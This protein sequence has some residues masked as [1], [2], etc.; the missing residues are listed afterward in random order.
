MQTGSVPVTADVERQDRSEATWNAVAPGWAGYADRIDELAAGITDRLLE[1]AGLRDGDRVLEL[2]CGPG[3][4]GLEAARRLGGTG[5]VVLSDIA[6]EMVALAARRAEQLGLTDV[7]TRRLDLD[8]IEEASSSFDVVLCREGLMFAG[9]PVRAASEIRRILR[10][11]GRAAV[12]VWAAR[13]AN[14]WLAIL[15]RSVGAE[16]EQPASQSGPNPF[17]LGE[18]ERLGAVLTRGGLRDVTVESL[19][20][21]RRFGSFEEWW[22]WVMA[23]A[24]IAHAV[25]SLPEP[26]VAR[27]RARAQE[28]IA[29][30]ATA[31]GFE[32]PGLALVASGRSPEA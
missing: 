30:Y 22:K 23:L 2:A 13:E 4:A 7:S 28:Q 6:P 24:P 12:S 26:T 9:D 27:I 1:L 16:M 10:P 20:V 21:P 25:L 3:G 19:R 17:S 5:E 18:P 29:V 8:R 14:P 15:G 31:D 32:I 11:G